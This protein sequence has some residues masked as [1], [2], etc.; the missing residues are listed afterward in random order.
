MM[1][2]LTELNKVEAWLK[3]NEIMYTREDND[4]F[5]EFADYHQIR[6]FN[7]T[8]RQIWDV[9]CHYGSY[10]CDQGLLE[11]MG[12]MVPEDDHVRGYMTAQ[13]VIDMATNYYMEV[14]FYC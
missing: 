9:V 13:D 12:D 14:G 6:V 7:R 3:E 5:F 1:R 11:I 10:G 2:D 4:N 8:G